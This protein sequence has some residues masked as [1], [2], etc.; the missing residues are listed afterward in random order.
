L[1]EGDEVVGA[2]RKPSL[3]IRSAG[4]TQPVTNGWRDCRSTRSTVALL[5][6]APWLDEDMN[7]RGIDLLQPSTT[8]SISP[9]RRAAAGM[10]R[11]STAREWTGSCTPA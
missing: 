10:R 7:E 8:C 3:T 4:G 6:D 9:R 2:I 1:Q 5:H 11:L